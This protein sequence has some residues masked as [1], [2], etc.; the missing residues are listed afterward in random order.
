[1]ILQQ[2]LRLCRGRLKTT[3]SLVLMRDLDG[4][5]CGCLGKDIVQLAETYGKGGVVWIFMCI[6]APQIDQKWEERSFHNAK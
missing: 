2:V 6:F 1:M 4:G 5:A 3:Y